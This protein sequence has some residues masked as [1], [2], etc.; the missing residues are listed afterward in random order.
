MIRRFIPLYFALAFTLVA[1][2]AVWYLKYF[3]DIGHPASQALHLPVLVTAGVLWF[4]GILNADP[5]V[6]IEEAQK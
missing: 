3:V 6:F 4:I 1:P 2:W 5:D